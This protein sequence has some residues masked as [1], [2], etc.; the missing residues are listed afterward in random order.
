MMKEFFRRGILKYLFC[1]NN[2]EKELQ[3]SSSFFIQKNVGVYVLKSLV[4]NY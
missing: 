2:Y 1:M 4:K 3:L